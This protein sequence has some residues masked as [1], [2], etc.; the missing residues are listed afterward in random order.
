MARLDNGTE[1]LDT[2]FR[3]FPAWIRSE[4]MGI[5]QIESFDSFGTIDVARITG[6]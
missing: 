5:S 6:K 2:R 1:I 3:P 4:S